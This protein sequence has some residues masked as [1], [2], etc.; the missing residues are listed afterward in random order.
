MKQQ[1]YKNHG[2]FV[3]L[4]HG[5]LFFMVLF[6]IGCSLVNLIMYFRHFNN[7]FWQG[8]VS[9]FILALS[10]GILYAYA[11]IFATTVQ[12]RAIRAEENLRHFALTGK[13]LD[14]GLTMSQIIALR[15]APDEEFANLAV[16]AVNKKLSNKEIKQQIKNWKADYHRV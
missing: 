16:E 15:F 11:R 14:K 13:F 6:A 12:D 2:R 4:F 3:P 8:P 7:G 1:N 5:V 9:L 10:I